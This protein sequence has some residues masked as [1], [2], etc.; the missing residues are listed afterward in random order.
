LISLA[1]V[2][3]GDDT[4]TRFV[5]H[6]VDITDRRKAREALEDLIRSK[7]E[8]IA[9]VSHELRTPLTVVHG[10][11]QELDN[12]WMGFSV[13][14]Q[15]EF[16]AMIAQQSAE[17]AHIVEDLLV[18]ARADIGKLP[19]QPDRVDLLD[20]LEAG[21]TASDG[22][23]PV[24]RVGDGSPI[25]FAD[26]NRVRQIIRNLLSNAQRYG[27]PRIEARCGTNG[28]VAWLEVADDGEGIP[29]EDVVSV[30]QPYQ[31]SHNAEGQ[32]LSVGLG[33]TVSLKLARLM[34]G[35]LDYR[36]VEGWSVFRLELPIAGSIHSVPAIAEGGV[37]SG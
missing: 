16:I 37:A 17:V 8:L 22:E 34:G 30:F 25:A 26:A 6:V 36:N 32:P 15:K 7:D 28:S 5:S 13:P 31:R 11:A 14:E 23:I 20:Q 2:N 4:T 3:V 10:L 21:V 18:A 19:I 35:T 27:G 12:G 33:L 29:E 1:P 9:S 24:H